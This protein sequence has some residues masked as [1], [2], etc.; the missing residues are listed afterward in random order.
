[1]RVLPVTVAIGIDHK[2]IMA[3]KSRESALVLELYI[4]C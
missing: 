1:M 4:I 2:G 3:G